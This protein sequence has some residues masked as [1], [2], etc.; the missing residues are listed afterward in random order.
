MAKARVVLVNVS[1]VAIRELRLKRHLSVATLATA[2]KVGK[3]TINNIEH[4]VTQQLRLETA[5]R[6]ARALGVAVKD[7][8]TAEK[9]EYRNPAL[10]ALGL[11]EVPTSA[12]DH[13]PLQSFEFTRYNQP[14]AIQWADCRGNWLRTS[15]GENPTS[16]ERW[17]EVAFSG[18]WDGWASVVAVHPLNHTPREISP[19][20]GFLGFSVKVISSEESANLSVGVRLCD[21]KGREWVLGSSKSFRATDQPHLFALDPSKQWMPCIIR[22]SPQPS[23]L[24]RWYLFRETSADTSPRILP[25]WS[26]VA[27]V[28]FQIGVMSTEGHPSPGNGEIWISPIWVGSQESIEKHLPKDAQQS[29]ASSKD[30]DKKRKSLAKRKPRDR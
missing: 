22:L 8:S 4:G 19:A 18:N 9:S 10:G 29:R 11:I 12:P 27:R 15:L 2:A 7:F 30:V 21:R 17:L 20:Q 14:I 28:V 24:H 1:K 25:D 16:G 23:S 5:N 3:T 26:C 6:I 13:V